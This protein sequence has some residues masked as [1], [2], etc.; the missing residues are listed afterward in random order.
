MTSTKTMLKTRVEPSTPATIGMVARMMG[1]APR[2]PA[3]D[4]SAF[5]CQGSRNGAS[6]MKTSSGR[7]TTVSTSP[8]MTAGQKSSSRSCGVTRRPSST[9]M[10]ICAIQP[11]PSAKPRVAG[12]CGSLALPRIIAARYTARNPLPWTRAPAAYADTAMA[13]TAIGYRPDAGSAT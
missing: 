12:Q 13:I 3:Q 7:A 9:N 1:T 6:E 11:S 4:M 5:S 10:P 8:T 2:S